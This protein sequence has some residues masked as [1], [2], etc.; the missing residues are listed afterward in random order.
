VNIGF[1]AQFV[2]NQGNRPTISTNHVHALVDTG[3]SE[4]CIDSGLAMQLNLPIVDQRRISGVGGHHDVNVHL[5]QIYVPS[6][7]FTMYGA[8]AAVEL[9]AGGQS[10]QALIGRTFL[11][12]FRMEYDGRTGTVSLSNDPRPTP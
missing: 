3:A 11:Q 4:C 2:P 10:H 7:N 5:A 12:E 8:F 6:L 9:A 1:D